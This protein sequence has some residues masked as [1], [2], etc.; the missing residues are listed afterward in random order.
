MIV[1]ISVCSVSRFLFIGNLGW[2]ELLVILIL[3]L[4][5]FGPKKLPEVAEA[6]G[7]SIRKFK[8]GS[9]DIKNEIDSADEDITEGEDK[10][11]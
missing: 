1:P 6:I 2:P 4:I 7:K 10:Q 3:V 9:T 5:I 8:K 11:G